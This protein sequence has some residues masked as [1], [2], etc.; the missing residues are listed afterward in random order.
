MLFARF[1]GKI[2]ASF[3]NI[4]FLMVPTHTLYSLLFTTKFSSVLQLKNHVPR[5][6]SFLEWAFRAA[7]VSTLSRYVI[8]LES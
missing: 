8:N 3:K 5:T 6:G 1:E 4:K 7:S 2:F